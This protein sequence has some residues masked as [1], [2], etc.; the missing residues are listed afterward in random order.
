VVKEECLA[1]TPRGKQSQGPA[2]LSTK[3]GEMTLSQGRAPHFNVVECS[4]GFI[5]VNIA[6]ATYIATHDNDETSQ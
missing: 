2:G 5:V 3:Q 1:D 4:D 6:I